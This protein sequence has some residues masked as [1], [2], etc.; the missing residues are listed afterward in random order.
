MENSENK[1]RSLLAF[2]SE[3]TEEDVHRE[4]NRV[5]S[6]RARLET[7]EGLLDL[8]LAVLRS[9]ARD[10]EEPGI[11]MVPIEEALVVA[12]ERVQLGST[13]EWPPQPRRYGIQSA[14]MNTGRAPLGSPSRKLVLSILRDK[15]ERVWSVSDVVDALLVRGYDAK[16]DSVRVMLQRLKKDRL[17]LRPKNGHYQA[18]PPA[19]DDGLL[20]PGAEG[21]QE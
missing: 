6:E 4:L 5:R 18:T 17:I 14:S 7:E 12:G 16:R 10:D 1:G 9:R 21:D 8:A 11:R 13:T 2:L 3:M 19:E 15:P 20:S